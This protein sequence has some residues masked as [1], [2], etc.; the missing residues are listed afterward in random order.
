MFVALVSQRSTAA[1]PKPRCATQSPSPCATQSQWRRPLGRL[2]VEVGVWAAEEMLAE[3]FELCGCLLDL[4]GAG[5]A[6]RGQKSV[7][8][9]EQEAGILLDD[10]NLGASLVAGGRHQ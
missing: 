9:F 5:I 7:V 3:L 4:L 10:C 6:E 1:P 8:F 2:F